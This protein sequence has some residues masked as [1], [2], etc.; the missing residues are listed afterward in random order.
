MRN[1]SGGS[2]AQATND[3]LAAQAETASTIDARET[4]LLGLI[5][6]QTDKPVPSLMLDFLERIY[7]RGARRLEHGIDPYS[8]LSV[9]RGLLSGCGGRKERS[10]RF[11]PTPLLM[12]TTPPL[13][14][15]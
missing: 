7:M 11:Q 14:S 9:N 12:N 10:R 6:Q 4:A 2:I 3:L 13:E 15:L 1:Y 5:Q 8:I